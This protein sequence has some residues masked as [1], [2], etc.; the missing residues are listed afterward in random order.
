MLDLS[1]RTLLTGTAAAALVPLARTPSAE[2][3]APPAGK[4]APGYYRY[5]VGDFELTQVTD[6]ARTFPLPETF[7]KNVKKEDVSKALEA[8]YMPKDQVT[9]VFNPL[10]V[11]TGSKLVL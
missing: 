9:I 5:K 4:Q 7:V 2:A 8:A 10:V 3:A 1:R 11:N 6:G